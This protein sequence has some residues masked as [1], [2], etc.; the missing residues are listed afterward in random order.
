M[1]WG[2]RSPQLALVQ[3]LVFL[4]IR[5][6]QDEWKVAFVERLNCERGQPQKRIT[7]IQSGV[8]LFIGSGVGLCTGP[9]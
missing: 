7:P 4:L 5:V 6:S 9:D 3:L 1:L 2:M 8:V